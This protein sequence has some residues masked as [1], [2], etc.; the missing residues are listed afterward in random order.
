[1]ATEIS[2]A[3]KFRLD[4]LFEAFSIVSEGSYVFLCNVTADFSRWSARAVDAFDLPGEYMVGAGALWER[5]IHPDDR[6]AYRE[7]IDALFRGEI[8]THD[9]QYRVKNREGN[10]VVCTCRG[11]IMR[12]EDGRPRY[13]GGVIRNHGLYGHIDALTG[14]RNQYAF[15]EDL[16]GHL[17]VRR[18]ISI[19]MMST[20]RFTEIN[21]IYGYHFGNLVLQKFARF[22]LDSVQGNGHVYRLDGTKFAVISTTIDDEEIRKRYNRVR[23]KLRAGVEVDGHFLTPQL[24]CGFLHLDNFDVNDRTVYACLNF[25]HSESKLHKQGDMVQFYSELTAEGTNRLEKMHAI[26]NSVAKN[27]NGFYLLYQPVVDAHSERLLGA[28]A[29]LRWKD[30]HFGTVPPDF[31]IPVLEQDPVF[32]GLGRWI[33]KTVMEEAKKF[34]S[35]IPDFTINVN[36]SYTQLE[37]PDFVN[38]IRELLEITGLPPQ[39]LCLEITERC[40]LLDLSLLKAVMLNL[41]DIGVRFALDDFG[42]GFSSLDIVR[43][44]SFDTT[45][46]DRSFVIDIEEDT[47]E[48]E[49]LSHFTA[50]ASTFGAKVCVEGIETTGMRDILQQYHVNS[51]QGYYYSRPIPPEELL[52]SPLISKT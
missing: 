20:S 42:T 34:L 21:E 9:L 27:Y 8:H 18:E 46:I 12:Y 4:S 3:D 13:F 41:K 44:L 15:F 47:K 33:L 40:R 50:I 31:F 29:L 16:K 1:M 22:L 28:E 24:N 49:M 25:A 32:I 17:A 10:Y 48:Q 38:M 36:L 11:T 45:K 52:E 51:F 19:S 30:G 26:R 2:N 35:L 5:L 37:N 14:L 43:S 39:N 7:N 6:K 23:D